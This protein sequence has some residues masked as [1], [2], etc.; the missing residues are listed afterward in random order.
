MSPVDQHPT[1][2]LRIPID[3]PPTRNN[4]PTFTDDPSTPRNH[5]FY[6]T[7]NIQWNF[8]HLVGTDQLKDR[9][10]LGTITS[11]QLNADYAAVMF[12]GKVQLHLVSQPTHPSSVSSPPLP[13]QVMPVSGVWVELASGSNGLGD[14]RANVHVQIHAVLFRARKEPIDTAT[15]ETWWVRFIFMV[16]S[17]SNT[18]PSMRTSYAMPN[19][20]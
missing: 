5:P 18:S 15:R 7:T 20:W 1:A 4:K 11:M 8:L 19:T 17:P 10:Y 13:Y 6:Q 12:E 16:T 3:Q 2:S 9:E 14:G